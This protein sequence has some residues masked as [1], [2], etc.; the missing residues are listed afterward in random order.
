M[1]TTLLDLTAVV[2]LARLAPSVH[3]TQPWRFRVDGDVLSLSR[4][5]DPERRLDVL[6]PAGR[7][8]VISCG[9]ALH[10]ARLA[11]RLQGM[12][13]EVV[14][15]PPLAEP[16]LLA[17]LVP[18]P[19]HPVSSQDVVL[20]EAARHRHTQRGRFEDRTLPPEV[21]AEI[22]AAGAEQ[23]AWVRVVDSPDDLA[24]LTVLLARAD[25]A[26][27]EEP[28][29]QEELARWTS[30]PPGAH[31]GVPQEAT[32]DVR[33]R[34]SSLR[35]RDFTGSAPASSAAADRPPAERPLAVVVGT[36][37]DTPDDWLRAGE[38]LMA[39]L[40]RAAVEGVQAQPLGQ[41]VDRESTRAR[42]G[43]QLGVVGHTQ[44]VLRMGYARPGPGAPRR[45]VDDVLD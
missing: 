26:E 27:R 11:L 14:R 38:A 29:Y 45:P 24:T 28:G 32:P 40:L 20:A 19:G 34:A 6:D 1:T 30:R 42:L 43:A 41:V 36:E 16:G 25:D 33:E 22:R 35:V 44:L 3:N 21:V 37:Q 23:G 15:L 31:D 13:A 4:D 8:Q 7:Q 2:D 10:L 9:A 5:T 12:D 17:H 39:V 18:V